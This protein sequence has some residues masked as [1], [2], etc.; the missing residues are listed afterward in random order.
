MAFRRIGFVLVAVLA[1]AACKNKDG[2]KAGASSA[3]LDKRCEA[4]AK[5]CADTDKHVELFRDECKAAAK[6]ECHDRLKC[7]VGEEVANCQKRLRATAGAGN[8]G[9]GNTGNGNNGANNGNS[10]N[11]G[12]GD[13]G[14]DRGG[15]DRGGGNDRGGND[16]GGGDDR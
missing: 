5:A 14:N 12:G 9:N 8:T 3:D 1:I 15:D 13:R 16:R 7:K 4:L 2:G 10:G 6:T 11:S